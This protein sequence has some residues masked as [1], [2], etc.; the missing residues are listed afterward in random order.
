MGTNSVCPESVPI[1]L[2][3][4]RSCFRLPHQVL[5]TD[6]VNMLDKEGLHDIQERYWT[7]SA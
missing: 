5:S 3:F 4:C 6:Y 7:E 1:L 2:F